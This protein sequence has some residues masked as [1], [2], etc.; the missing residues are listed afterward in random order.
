M[1]ADDAS[2]KV[3]RSS[4]SSNYML[5]NKKTVKS[6]NWTSSH[7]ADFIDFFETSLSVAKELRLIKIPIFQWRS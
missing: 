3:F 2:S 1:M 6:L 7:K 5:A 4:V